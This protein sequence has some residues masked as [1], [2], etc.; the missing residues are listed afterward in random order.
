MRWLAD[1]NMSRAVVKA[2]RALGF[3]VTFIAET[4][5]GI[6]D[7]EVLALAASE[8]RILITEDKGFGELI[9]RLKLQHTGVLLVRSTSVSGQDKAKYICDVILAHQ[10]SLPDAFTVMTDDTVRIRRT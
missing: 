9:F 10:T 4:T 3:D 8:Q 5:P 6:T 2:I 1:E 7:E